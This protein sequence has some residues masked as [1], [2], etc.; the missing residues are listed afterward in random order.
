MLYFP[1]VV[2]SVIPDQPERKR[3]D[4]QPKQKRHNSEKALFLLLLS[5]I[6]LETSKATSQRKDAS[7]HE[8]RYPHRACSVV[9]FD[10]RP[11]APQFVIPGILGFTIL[12]SFIEMILAAILINSYVSR[13]YS[14]LSAPSLQLGQ[15]RKIQHAC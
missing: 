5:L 8:G 6:H 9:P 1:H 2:V 7:N 3:Q 11:L 12:F 13:V 4:G 15:S 14:H 10:A